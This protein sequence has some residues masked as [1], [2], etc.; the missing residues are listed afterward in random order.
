MEL[1]EY[2]GKK[3]KVCNLEGLE[4][5]GICY[6][7]TPAIDNEPEVDQIDLEREGYSGLLSITAPEIK[8]IEIIED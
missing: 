8:S 5:T 6:C 2:I 7:F 1:Y 3:V 4:E